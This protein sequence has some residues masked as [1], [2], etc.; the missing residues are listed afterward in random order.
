MKII[1]TFLTLFIYTISF[2]QTFTGKVIDKQN[3]PISFA[4]IV[5]KNK[6]DNSI[7]TGVISDENGEFS[8]KTKKKIYS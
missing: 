5:A 7:I 4:N 2:A 3:Q 8:I 6:T 1:A